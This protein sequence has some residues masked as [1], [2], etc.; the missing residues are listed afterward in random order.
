MKNSV[1]LKL[2]NERIFDS[3]KHLGVRDQ[4]FSK[5]DKIH[6]YSEGWSHVNLCISQSICFLSTK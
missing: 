2:L 4:K 5:T 1:E 6:L 3:L